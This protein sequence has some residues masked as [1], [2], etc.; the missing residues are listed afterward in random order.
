MVKRFTSFLLSVSLLI[1]FWM[2]ATTNDVHAYIDFGSGSLILQA[3][4]ASFFGALFT[5]KVYWRRLTGHL[6]AL[7]SRVKRLKTPIK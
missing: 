1:P 4:L 3:L 5:L 7:I 6:S 2:I